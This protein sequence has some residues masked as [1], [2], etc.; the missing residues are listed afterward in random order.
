M[1]LCKSMPGGTEES[2]I[3]MVCLSADTLYTVNVTKQRIMNH[4]G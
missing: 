3:A 1:V 2:A 4:Q